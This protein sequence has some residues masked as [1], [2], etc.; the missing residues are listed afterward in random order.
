MNY[1]LDT[2]VISEWC[3]PQPSVNVVR[4]CIETDE[5]RLYISVIALAEIRRGIELLADER[6]REHLSHWLTNDL[7][8]RF[9]RRILDVDE[10]IANQWGVTMAA[11]QKLGITMSSMDALLAATAIAHSMTLVTRNTNDF[12]H[13]HIA[14]L[15]PWQN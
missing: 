13:L 4:W 5:D 10:R 2:N 6:R 7:S 15:D 8:I 14:I 11:S 9:E 1:L 12:G 3:K